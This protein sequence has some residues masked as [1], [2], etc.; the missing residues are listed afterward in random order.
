VDESFVATLSECGNLKD[1]QASFPGSGNVSKYAGQLEYQ[2]IVLRIVKQLRSMINDLLE[3]TRVEAGKLTIE[4][5]CT[6]VS[7]AIVYTVSTLQGA[8][9]AKGITLS[10]DMDCRLPSANAD[11]TRIQQIL[12]VLLRSTRW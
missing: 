6:S 12:I 3:V 8:A 1:W 7:D 5:Q 2:Q 11:P 4:L 9:T 10:S